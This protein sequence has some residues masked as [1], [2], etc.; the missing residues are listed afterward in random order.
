MEKSWIK[1]L[2]PYA[3][4]IAVFA[5]ISVGYFLPELIEG[6]VL[7]Q[8]DTRQGIAIA[9]EINEFKD[10]TGEVSRWTNSAFGGMPT[11]Q[12]AP[13]YD[14]TKIVNL[15]N[16]F[17]TLF[18][19]EP[20][21]YIFLML[22]G[23]FLLLKAFGLR[24]EIAVL[25]AV[26]YAF[27][28]YFFII[29]EAGH[30]WKFITLA[31]IPPTIAGIVW[32]YR[33]RYLLGGA[34]AALF[35]TYQIMSNHI[36][37]TY[38]FLFV[39]AAL[40]IAYFIQDLREKRLDS[41]FKAS[42]ILVVSALIAVAINS[43]NLYHT[44]EYSKESIRG[45]GG[46]TIAN[47]N[48]TPAAQSEG[49]DRDYIVQWSY[50]KDE[51]WTL[52][53]P[54]VKGGSTGYLMEDKAAMDQ[55]KPEYRQTLG[56]MNQYWG[57]QPFTSGPVYVGAF[58]LFLFILSLFIVRGP[59]KWALLAVCILTIFLS[60]G[61]N[62]MWFTNLFIDYF[63]MYDKFRTVSSILVVP[64]FIIPLLAVLGLNEI[65]KNPKLLIERKR[66]V[67]VSFL[68]TGGVSLVIALVPGLFFDFFSAQEANAFLPQAVNNPQVAEILE[69]LETAR[70][71]VISMDGWRSFIII[72]LGCALLWLYAKQKIGAK[73][74]LGVLIILCTVD[75]WNVNKRYL[76]GKDFHNKSVQD[77]TF[78]PSA[79]DQEILKDKSPNYRVYN[80]A[81][82]S[83][84]DPM[85]SYYHKSVGGYHA[86]K[87]RRFQDLID[88]QLSN[89]NKHVLD[90]LNTKY[91]II[92]DQGDGTLPLYK[93]PDALGNAWFVNEV[94]WA[95]TP[96]DEMK[97][98]TDFNPATTA[99]VGKEYE[100]ALKASAVSKDST[101]SITLT[102]YHPNK[103]VYTSNNTSEGLG[104]FSEIYYP[105]GWKATID[106]KD[107]S[108][109]RVDYL[110]RG[111]IIPAG[112]HE[113]VFTFDPQS[114][115]IT[116][117]LAYAAS[118]LLIIGFFVV[119]ILEIRRSKKPSGDA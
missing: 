78:T 21:G 103:L 54:N 29:I 86:A 117:T 76:S 18:L 59:L 106:G 2:L 68:L 58:V 10:A 95:D 16:G 62:M 69:N 82:N 26:A 24:N 94:K 119:A 118:I 89:G 71:Y 112:K 25:G 12:I 20:A 38:Y 34:V 43:S 3:A 35:A 111:L 27:S 114:L 64:E 40:V 70:K 77:Q 90:M 102:T 92:P 113:I 42:G 44:Y 91:I 109:L 67:L 45:K 50:G 87:L 83:F 81:V 8:G 53:V 6:K 65:V 48:V 30:I 46:L 13:G 110:L 5:I 105:Y 47:D 1:R 73:L 107:A 66:D 51:T 97:D 61:R 93:N 57:D 33:G 79:V 63:P 52:L 28:S 100:S 108:I 37:M 99:I 9:H 14:S 11:Y 60:W 115:K 49:L 74:M 104:V 98:L 15:I 41:F 19:P 4:V 88:H 55:I 7:F 17:F 39:V 75:M 101:A 32:A 84:N 80:T 85:T 116:E 72:A 31:Y 22:F 96:N 56:Q 36:Q 23:F